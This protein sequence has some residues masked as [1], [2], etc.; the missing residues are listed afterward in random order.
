MQMARKRKSETTKTESNNGT[1][2]AKALKENNPSDEAISTKDIST[3]DS[4]VC[5]YA[6]FKYPRHINMKIRI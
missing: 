6:P 3:Q 1:E 2:K 4:K 5:N